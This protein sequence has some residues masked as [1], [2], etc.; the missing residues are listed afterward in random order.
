M[1]VVRYEKLNT[2]S[3]DI[4]KAT[5]IPEDDARI[6]ADHLTTS[7][8]VGHDSH[9]VW[10]LPRYLSGLRTGYNRWEDHIVLREG[11]SF[12]LTDGGGA[13]GIVAVTKALGLAVEKAKNATFGMLGLRNVTHIGRLGDFPPESPNRV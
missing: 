7:N 1:P 2:L 3:Y 13:N 8:L 5:G 11:P 6:L 12:V 4:F 10:F 9:G